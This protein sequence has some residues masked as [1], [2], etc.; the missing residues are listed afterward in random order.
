[1]RLG[2]AQTNPTVGDID[3]NLAGILARIA[4]ARS[5]GCEA[6][7]FPELALCGYSPHDLLW[8]RGFIARLQ[9]GQEAIREAS[10][11]IGV[12][13][14][15]VIVGGRRAP[16]NLWDPS[17]VADGAGEKRHNVAL[18]FADRETV[19]AQPKLHL[20]SFDVFC[21]ERHFS[22]GAGSE[23]FRLCGVRVGVNL[24]EDM[25]VEDGPTGVQAGL[26]AE[27]VVNISSS[28]FFLGKAALRRRIGARL[29]GEHRIWFVYVNRVGGQDDVV[30]DGGSFVCDPEGNLRFQAP[31]FEEGL[32]V[33][34]PESSRATAPPEERDTDLLRRG[35]VMA[36]GDYFRR[37]GFSQ[38]LIGLS[39]GIDSAVVA[40]LAA[41]ALGSD[42][43]NGVS[44]PSRITTK[45]SRDDAHEV[46]SRLGIGWEEIEIGEAIETLSDSLSTPPDGIAAENLQARTRGVLLMT[47]ANQRSAMVLAT[48]NKSEIAV[49]YNTLYG[50]T[51]GALA[52]I[53]DLYKRDVV[54]LAEAYGERIPERVRHKPPTAELR[55]GQ[56]D[57]DD[58][59]PYDLLD[60]ILER[61]VERQASR[62]DLLAE[63]FEASVSY[64]HLTLPTN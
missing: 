40:A 60:R 57:E 24:C 56:R 36:I 32:F 5:A 54:R 59:P 61:L 4:E 48:G 8:S 51:V 33:V 47:L 63:G 29:A 1:M 21:E 15:G 20:P 18:L 19:G 13:V 3:H 64:T 14:G 62:S 30:Y 53:G 23:V 28:P 26:G 43:V 46:A 49:G 50:D 37:N 39:G 11:E 45:E 17:S 22:P 44:M 16:A 6:V 42:A 41:E 25:W 35:L 7:I 10:A 12:I 52:P 27:W 38:A 31:Y 55:P 34:E 58:L 9:A 2:I